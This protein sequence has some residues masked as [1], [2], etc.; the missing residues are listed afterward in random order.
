MAEENGA[1]AG[2]D[3]AGQADD[4]SARVQARVIAQYIKDLSFEVPAI[5]RVTAGLKQSPS[6]ALE[7]NVTGRQVEGPRF[8]SA[9]DFTA[10]A[11]DDEGVIY[12]MEMVYAGVVHIE[13]MPKDAL[14]PFLLVNCPTI[15]FPF[16]RRVI[17]DI[18]RESGMPPLMLDPIDFGR[19]YMERRQQA[20]GDQ[21]GDSSAQA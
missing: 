6:L 2:H 15:I 3:G 5:D 20:A 19:L 13:Q 14:E 8:E 7:I 10:K 12:D 1:A 16:M 11:S 4:Q 9:I 21:E 18:T 17:A